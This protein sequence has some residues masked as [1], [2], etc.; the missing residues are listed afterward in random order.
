MDGDAR[1]LELDRIRMAEDLRGVVSGDVIFAE[2][3][4]SLYATDASLFTIPPLGVVR[5]RT[6]DDVAATLE[7]ATRHGVS[8]HPR[9][10]GTGL[11][12][13]VLGQGLILDCSR[14][15]RR[16]VQT[17]DDTVRVQPGVTCQQLE[18]HLAGIGRCFGPDPANAS[19]TT[20]GGMIGR[21]TSGSR[22]LKYG[23][24]RDRIR[25]AEVV[26]SDGLV[27]ELVPTTAATR[28]D[29][30]LTSA[31]ASRRGALARGVVAVHASAGEQLAAM[32][33]S[34]RLVHGGYR[35]DDVVQ[36][37][38]GAGGQ[39]P[40]VDLPRLLCGSSGTLAVVTAVTLATEPTSPGAA[41][42]LF[43]FDS[44]EGAAAAAR[45]LQ[46]L[47]PSACDLFD[48]RHLALSRT[49]SA[50]FERLVPAV[51]EAGLLVEFSGGER[52][53]WNRQLDEAVQ[54][55]RRSRFRCIDVRRAESATD[56][57]LFWHLS[58]TIVATLHGVR[59]DVRPV[60][61]ME[62]VV[63]PPARLPEF[64]VAYQ[65]LLKRHAATALLFAHAGHGQLHVRPFADPRRPGERQ[66]LEA[67]ANELVAVV[68]E[69]DGTLGGE[70]GLGLSRTAFFQQYAPEQVAVCREV[71]R[72]FDPAGLLNPGKIVPLAEAPAAAWRG[73]LAAASPAVSLPVLTWTLEQC[74]DEVD[75][76]NGCGACRSDEEALRMCPR[77]RESPGEE[78]SPRAKANLVAGLL[79]GAVDLQAAGLESIQAIADTCFNC[80]QC[81][82]ECAAGV[83]I[84]ALVTELKA[85]SVAA[86]GLRWT[87]WLL[88][89]ADRLSAL[90][91]RLGPMANWA[92]RNRQARWLLEKLCGIAQG[93]QLPAFTGNKLLR[94]ASR[95]GL[96]RPSRRAGP[97]VLY[98]LDTFARR[99]DPLV[100]KAFVALLE[101]NGVGV[102]IDPRQVAS[103]IT[104][105][106]AGD[107][108][109]AR[110]LA[111][112]NLQVLA[113]AV[114][115]GYRIVATE[116]AAVTAIRHDYPLLLEDEELSGVVAATCH[117]TDYLWE[118]H[119]DG[120]FTV[121]FEPLPARLLYHQ[122]CHL[123]TREARG[124]SAD[125]LRLIPELALDTRPTGC[126]GMAG[127]FGLDRENYRASLRI[128]RT[129]LAAVREPAIGGGVTEC[130]TCRLQ[131]EQGVAKAT[132]HPVVLL[133]AAAGLLPGAT[134]Q[135]RLRGVVPSSEQS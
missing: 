12:G 117:A 123:R 14:F 53:D 118:M 88:S 101:R 33:A 115:L 7:W 34:E 91:G 90:G 114:R 16:I 100:A 120:R 25:A 108:E 77:F 63:I 97:R 86:H 72:L 41:V 109:E 131:M 24:V 35:L 55:T 40:V 76:C 31:D 51:A 107:I 79:N 69:M 135:E 50:T 58:R 39:P 80:H 23:A 30:E 78:S 129:L 22:F 9:G 17:G 99:H 38:A 60:Q 122:P 112:R 106:A 74:S 45:R 62:D 57:E 82:T 102:F 5:P 26:F 52:A 111:R 116:P 21:N 133:A 84:P 28:P 8:V 98:F 71:K 104:A 110:R 124:V 95:R 121:D 92:I 59:G 54:H 4:R 81:R 93:R 18:T 29:G 3:G 56:V 20:L 48:K 10:A 43:F 66:R 37:K 6:V 46:S 49:A 36:P 125:L 89:R 65:E 1:R 13:D 15:L 113:E 96:T 61:F 67:L 42:G 44:L 87:P 119:R 85:A 68:V 75:A 132:V 127:T 47:G 27:A 70:Q 11:A 2:A 130:S 128:G 73:E 19:V 64:L 134:V 103:G 126:S 94:W 83:D 105:V 32:A